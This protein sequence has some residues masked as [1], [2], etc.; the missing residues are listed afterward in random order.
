MHSI[1]R[2]LHSMLI[3]FQAV[4]GMF[5]CAETIA[6]YFD[7][8]ADYSPELYVVQSIRQAVQIAKSVTQE[9]VHCTS[10][11]PLDHRGKHT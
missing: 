4:R 7:I 8:L 2:E 5:R 1:H 10:V 6:F 3:F 9:G 11:S